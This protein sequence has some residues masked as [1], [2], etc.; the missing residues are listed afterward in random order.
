MIFYVFLD[1]EVIS[2]ANNLGVLGLQSLNAILRGF[3]QNCFVAEF[4]DYR[5]Q[6]AIKDKVDSLPE[7]YDRTIIKKLFT[8]LQKRNR[9][10]YCLSPDHSGRKSDVQCAIE[11]AISSLLD[12]LLLKEIPS[13]ITIPTGIEVVTLTTYQNCNFECN[14]S[15]LASNGKTFR[16][17]DLDE[18]DFLDKN[19]KKALRYACRIEVCDR[20][21]GRKFGDNYLYTTRIMHRWLEQVISDPNN[22]KLIFHCGKP[23]DEYGPDIDFI[24]MQIAGLKQGRLAE[25]HIELVFYDHPT[26]EKCL[27]HERFIFT[28]QIAFEIGRGMDFIDRIT[29]KNR[30]V[31]IGIKSQKE[32]EDLLE[33][34]RNGMLTPI[35]V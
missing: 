31:S 23:D 10:I 4:E 5:I 32:V 33:F 27:P 3:L 25:L 18:R 11:Q 9:F 1:P 16:E 30:D 12:L 2:F 19:F 13:D 6:Q 17:G 20:L 26:P 7:S 29:Q 8:A 28:D 22:C 34:Y 24:R 21:F 14:R 15:L 35:V